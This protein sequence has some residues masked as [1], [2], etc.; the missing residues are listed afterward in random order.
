MIIFVT[1]YIKMPIVQ[2][3]NVQIQS[4]PNVQLDNWTYVQLDSVQMS[5]C[6][7]WTLSKSNTVYI[8][9]I[10]YPIINSIIRFICAFLIL[11][12]SRNE[13]YHQLVILSRFIE[14]HSHNQST[15]TLIAQ[16]FVR[17]FFSPTLFSYCG[18]M[19]YFCICKTSEEMNAFGKNIILRISGDRSHMTEFFEFIA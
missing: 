3:D 5:N 10:Q 9:L 15:L 14:M 12:K 7:N 11:K 1:Q 2:L 8:V 18:T 6:R 4:C 16:C 19:P 13:K 17:I